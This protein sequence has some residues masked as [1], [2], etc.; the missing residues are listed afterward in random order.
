[1]STSW[2]LVL[3]AMLVFAEIGL[4][5]EQTRDVGCDAAGECCGTCYTPSC[6][7]LWTAAAKFLYLQRDSLDGTPLLVEDDSIGSATLFDASQFDF[8]FE[9]GLEVS[10][11][12]QFGCSNDLEIRYFGFYDADASEAFTLNVPSE[13]PGLPITVFTTPTVVE[14]AY[15]TE[16]QSIELNW[17]RLCCNGIH[18]QGGFR[19]ARLKEELASQLYEPNAQFGPVTTNT[20][21]EAVNN[22]YG[23]QLGADSVLWKC[24]CRWQVV[25]FGKG[26]VYYADAE[27]DFNS[28]DNRGLG[29]VG[30]TDEDGAAFLG[31]AGVDLVYEIN[32]HWAVSLGAQLMWLSGVAIA[33]D[34]AGRVSNL[35][36][37]AGT[38]DLD[39]NLGGDV[40]LYGFSAGVSG[41]W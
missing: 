37:F 35:D 7:S 12:R 29:A 21:L 6:D 4:T 30:G 9:P 22:L 41:R 15:R 40:L 20:R 19:W 36:P 32:S 5:Q 27:V 1:M 18:F 2:K 13:F 28:L 11:I 33:S 26:G 3:S 17:G 39:G 23:L 10:L 25:G 24:G 31:E 34:H 16:V 14:S 38:A 8:D